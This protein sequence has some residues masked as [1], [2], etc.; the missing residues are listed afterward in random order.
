MLLGAILAFA[1]FSCGDDEEPEI[2][3]EEE[4]IT[5]MIYTLT[6]TA[7]NAVFRFEDLDGDGAMEPTITNATL[8]ANT[9]YQGTLEFLNESETPAEDI[10]E[11]VAEEDLEHQVFFQSSVVSV[12]YADEDPDGNPLGL[13]STL[14]TGDAASGNLTITLR[15]EPD[16]TAAGVS[17]GDI[18]NAGGETDIAVTFTVD[19]Q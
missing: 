7:G 8:A 4:V 19:V 16:K 18:A 11:E 3:N 1:T 12:A 15:H 2:E 10:T 14:T 5:T 17:D 6:S 9:T 13:A